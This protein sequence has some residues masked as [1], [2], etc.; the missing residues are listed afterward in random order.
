MD[1]NTW[2]III[3]IFEV[4]LLPFA[5]WVVRTLN[6]MLVEIKELRVVLIGVDGKNGLRSRVRRIE[7]K[8]TGSHDDEDDE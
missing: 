6:A 2:E 5:L 8:L 1:Q 4:A 3:K 7:K